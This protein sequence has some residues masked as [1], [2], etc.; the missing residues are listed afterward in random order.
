MPGLAKATAQTRFSPSSSGTAGVP[1]SARSASRMR[2]ALSA[3]AIWVPATSAQASPRPTPTSLINTSDAP[4]ASSVRCTVAGVVRDSTYASAA[5]ARVMTA[6]GEVRPVATLIRV[7]DPSSG[8]RT[9]RPALVPV[10]KADPLATS[11][12]TPRMLASPATLV[13]DG[14]APKRTS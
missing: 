11:T 8:T 2:P 6:P 10:I 3:T 7:P 14:A 12:A 1:G 9:S 13:M 5:S 4:V